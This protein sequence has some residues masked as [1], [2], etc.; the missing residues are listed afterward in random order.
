MAMAL[1]YVK[2]FVGCSHVNT[3]TLPG[4]VGMK[5]SS[6]HGFLKTLISGKLKA[7]IVDFLKIYVY[8][9]KLICMAHLLNEIEKLPHNIHM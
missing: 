3:S 8:L 2:S 1:K 7:E 9:T 5:F 4:C 6:R